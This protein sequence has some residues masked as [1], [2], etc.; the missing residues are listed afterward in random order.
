MTVQT[1]CTIADVKDLLS[2]NGVLYR[3]DDDESGAVAG[4]G[5]EST[6]QSHAIELAAV[7]MNMYLQQTAYTLTALANNEWCKWC[8]AVKAAVALCRRRGNPVP[9]SLLQEEQEFDRMLEMLRKGQIDA[10]PGTNP[11]HE[12]TPVTINF[13]T[14]PWRRHPVRRKDGSSTGQRPPATVKRHDE[15]PYYSSDDQQYSGG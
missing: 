4:S 13:T 14:E 3:T 12:S 1:F 5:T 10:I 6:V 11:S 7:K 8:N 2:D 15:I 9:Q